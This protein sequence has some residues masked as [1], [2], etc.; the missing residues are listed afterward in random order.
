MPIS[1]K[2]SD[3]TTDGDLNPS[4]QGSSICPDASPVPSCI[5]A[6]LGDK[7]DCLDRYN[8]LEA[9]RK[10]IEAFTILDQGAHDGIYYPSVQFDHP[11]EHPFTLNRHNHAPPLETWLKLAPGL[12]Q[13]VKLLHEYYSSTFTKGKHSAVA[14]LQIHPSRDETDGEDDEQWRNRVMRDIMQLSEALQKDIR[15]L[16]A[17]E[18]EAQIGERMIGLRLEA[19]RKFVEDQ[20]DCL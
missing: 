6:D 17:V 7:L 10:A 2:H 19:L 20:S 4:S 18:R 13:R 11:N 5:V 16:G 12:M 15:E 14:E 3:T 1:Q 9:I 8:A